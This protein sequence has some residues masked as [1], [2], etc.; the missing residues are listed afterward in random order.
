[1]FTWVLATSVLLGAPALKSTPKSVKPPDGVWLAAE[2]V[3]EGDLVPDPEGR[4]TTW[5]FTSSARTVHCAILGRSHKQ[6][7]CY[8]DLDGALEADFDEG[9]RLLKAIWKVDGET[10]TVCMGWEGGPRPTQYAA[11]KGSGHLLFVLK[12]ARK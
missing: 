12:R 4:Q 10:L 3:V 11:P 7:A 1:M 2:T 5:E 6:R 8:R 9:E